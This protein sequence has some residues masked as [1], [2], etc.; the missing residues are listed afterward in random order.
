M[1]KD[2]ETSIHLVD[3]LRILKERKWVIITFFMIIVPFVTI[4]TFYQ[5]S[6]YRATASLIVETEEP[7]ILNFN[8]VMTLG[9]EHASNYD[10]YINTQTEVIK[11]RQIINNVFEDLNLEELL[12]KRA[13]NQE[14][15]HP[16]EKF[17]QIIM[18]PRV[19]I[20]RF[21]TKNKESETDSEFLNQFDEYYESG[22]PYLIE[23]IEKIDVGF[24]RDSQILYISVE[25]EDKLLATILANKIANV[26]IE[27]NSEYRLKAFSEA[28]DFL[29]KEIEKQREKLKISEL[30]LQEYRE[31]NDIISFDISENPNDMLGKRSIQNLKD[32]LLELNL[33]LSEYEKLYREKNPKMIRLKKQIEET[34]MALEKERN[35]ALEYEKK[36]IQYGVLKREVETNKNLYQVML[37]RQ[38]EITISGELKTSNVH[39][40]DRASVPLFPSRPNKGVNILLSLLV[41]LL[42]G[43]GLAFFFNYLNRRVKHYDKVEEDLGLHLLGCISTVK[44]SKRGER[45]R[46]MDRAWHVMHYPNS[47]VAEEFRKVRT[48]IYFSLQGDVTKKSI[49]FTSYSPGEGKTFVSFNVAQALSFG[50]SKTLLV[51]ADFRRPKHHNY[52]NYDGG[53]GLVT[54]LQGKTDLHSTILKTNL[55]N[56]YVMPRGKDETA[57]G[58]YLYELLNS[59]RMWDFVKE[60]S[61]KFDRIIYDVPPFG[62]INDTFILGSITKSV[63][64]IIEYNKINREK[65]VH[66][67]QLFDKLNIEIKGVI[68]NKG[69][70]PQDSFYYHK[71]YGIKDRAVHSGTEVKLLK[72]DKEQ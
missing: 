65:I 69:P 28:Q 3:Y 63:I 31:Q 68:L 24:A 44:S 41:G 54:F 21:K 33:T 22:N 15:I 6:V 10:R 72:H 12:A 40:K 23:L 2:A 64:L 56:L 61:K 37:N 53:P 62:V 47:L 16:I 50:G 49:V 67:K 70:T 29:A 4:G 5:K 58:K 46:E 59:Q 36:A 17:Y 1:N 55:P 57:D 66:A 43:T 52:L 48:N 30:Q 14:N 34:N 11:S 60:T 42:G 45:A 20:K 9:T 13:E 32:K 8:D 71:Y 25:D 7:E 27:Q 39:F 35:A 38:K 51:D 18:D 19:L 26:Y